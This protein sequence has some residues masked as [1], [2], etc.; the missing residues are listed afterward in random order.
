[1]LDSELEFFKD[2]ECG[3][4]VSDTQ[5]DKIFPSDARK[6]SRIDWTPVAVAIEATR[7]FSLKAWMKLRRKT[8]KFST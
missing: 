4:K 3:V 6:S 7:A 5:F 2:L 8:S 1:M